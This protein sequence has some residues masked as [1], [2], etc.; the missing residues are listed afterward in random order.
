M[1][2][3]VESMVPRNLHKLYLIVSQESGDSQ[4]HV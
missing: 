3:Q 4:V 1:F 2:T